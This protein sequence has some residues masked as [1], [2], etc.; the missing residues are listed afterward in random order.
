M[1]IK[2]NCV[3]RKYFNSNLY[4]INVIICIDQRL[5][6]KNSVV[7][8][9]TSI[10]DLSNPKWRPF[11][12]RKTIQIMSWWLCQVEKSLKIW[13]SRVLKLSEAPPRLC[14]EMN[15][16]V[17]WHALVY[18]AALSIICILSNFVSGDLQ[19]VGWG[20]ISTHRIQTPHILFWDIGADK[21][22]TTRY[23]G[24]SVQVWVQVRALASS[25][26]SN[27]AI[28]E[29]NRRFSGQNQWPSS[30]GRAPA[31]LGLVWRAS[32]NT[33]RFRFC[34][35]RCGPWQ[36]RLWKTCYHSCYADLVR[37]STRI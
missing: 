26:G 16:S 21:T 35:S 4:P 2:K 18:I 34:C 19:S 32:T 12:F 25:K 27:L 6:V 22:F 14:K 5:A 10:F 30:W 24:G 31:L 3:K 9:L 33:G 28:S 17:D 15:A 23:S 29:G 11:L 36:A 7:S 20:L 8:C 1:S 37:E 13:C